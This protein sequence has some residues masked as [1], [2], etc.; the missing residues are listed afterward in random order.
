M[1][2]VL[3]VFFE[4]FIGW[5][6]VPKRLAMKCFL[7]RRKYMF[8][9]MEQLVFTL[10]LTLF[11]CCTFF[12]LCVVLNYFNKYK[13]QLNTNMNDEFCSCPCNEFL[14]Q[15]S[16]H[17]ENQKQGNIL[18]FIEVV[19]LNHWIIQR[20]LQNILFS[21]I[22]FGGNLRIQQSVVKIFGIYALLT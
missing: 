17:E 12:H 7:W 6:N 3:D 20:L 18:W 13:Q 15:A 5:M 16:G 22:L 10:Y 2:F 14:N 11:L 21:G 8:I 4:E 19:F 1:K 9:L